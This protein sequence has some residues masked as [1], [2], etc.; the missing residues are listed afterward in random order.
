VAA[1][2]LERGIEVIEDCAQAH[3]ATVGGRAAGTIGRAGAFSFYPT[4]NLGAFGDGGAVL[5]SDAELD[6]RLRLVRQY[7]QAER[8]NHVIEG[9]NSRLD[10]LQAALLRVRLEHLD[11]WNERR[12][13]IAQHYTE[14]L[15]GTAVR[16]LRLLPDRD[17]AFHLFVVTAPE[18]ERFQAALAERGVSTLVHYPRPVHGHPPYAE[19]GRGPVPLSSSERLAE[20]VVSLPIYPELTDAEV[21]Y[22][23]DSARSAAAS[24]QPRTQ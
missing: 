1:I 10:E 20:Q 22:V 13:A 9:V 12:R 6:E 11:G 24:G 19:L 23:A 17:H 8:Y 7:G 2:A 15:A 5:T 3:G 14:A 21:E 16:P 18:R 4:K